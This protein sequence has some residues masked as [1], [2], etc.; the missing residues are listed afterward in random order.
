MN[1]VRTS[2]MDRLLG[3]TP[4]KEFTISNY[5]LYD[6]IIQNVR[7]DLQDLL[8]TRKAPAPRLVESTG[9]KTTVL[10]YGMED[11]AHFNPE[12]DSDKQRLKKLLE[13]LINTY[14]PRLKKVKV[15][16]LE[17]ADK[18]DFRI[19]FHIDAVL[20]IEE[21]VIPV[22]FNSV[23]DTSPTHFNIQEASYE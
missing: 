19:R 11:F 14:E 16:L 18:I 10:N 8:N 12:S 1:E 7:S 17:N 15:Q 23:M 13:N 6:T 2:V 4:A 22:Q 5:S 21:T 20:C 9:L 3:N